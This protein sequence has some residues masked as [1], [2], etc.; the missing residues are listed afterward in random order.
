[1]TWE[2]I[3]PA[4]TRSRVRIFEIEDAA[5]GFVANELE[6]IDQY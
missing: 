5:P 4:A 2:G 6:E 1:M 3:G